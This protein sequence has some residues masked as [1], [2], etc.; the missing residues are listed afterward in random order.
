ML[1]FCSF[2]YSY[3]HRHYSGKSVSHAS[4]VIDKRLFGGLWESNHWLFSLSFPLFGL[5]KFIRFWSV[6]DNMRRGN[7]MEF[8]WSAMEFLEHFLNNIVH[9]SIVSFGHTIYGV[10]VFLSV[11]GQRKADN[12]SNQWFQFEIYARF[13]ESLLLVSMHWSVEQF[14]PNK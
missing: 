8:L 9:S 14:C 4:T 12:M 13:T 10:L 2:P 7:S 5:L 3:M 6:W 1:C 11:S